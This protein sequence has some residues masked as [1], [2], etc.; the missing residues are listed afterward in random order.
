MLDSVK[1]SIRRGS[2]VQ[3]LITDKEHPSMV[4]LVEQFDDKLMKCILI[5]K[6]EGKVFCIERDF[7][8][9]EVEYVGAAFYIPKVYKV[10]PKAKGQKKKT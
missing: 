5:S 1:G 3:A 4:F 9:D 6:F 2:L 10:D 8:Y 7:K